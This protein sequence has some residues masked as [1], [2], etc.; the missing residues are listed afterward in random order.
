MKFLFITVCAPAVQHLCQLDKEMQQTDS[1]IK[2]YYAVE[3]FSPEKTA[4]MI[5]DMAEA[6]CI[7][8][9]LMGA[10]PT[11]IQAVEQGLAHAP[12]QILPYGASARSY[13]RLGKFTAEGMQQKSSANAPSME[14]MKRMQK[15]AKT[16][17]KVLPGKMRDMRN[18]I[19]LMQYFQYESLDSLRSFLLLMRKEYGGEKNLKEPPAPIITKALA[20]YNLDDMSYT[21]DPNTYADQQGF[22]QDLPTAALLFNAYAYPTDTSPCVKALADALS[23][24]CNVLALGCSGAFSDYVDQLKDYL[25]ARAWKPVSVILNCRPF[26]LGAGPMGGDT[27]QA[28]DLLQDTDVPYLHPFFLT[29]RTVEDWEESI[30]GCSPSEILISVMLPEMDGI[31]DIVP[32]GA[33]ELGSYEADQDIQIYQ[34]VPI[35]ERIQHLANRV[36][37]YLTLQTKPNAEK[38]LAIL[39]YNYPPGEASLFGGAFL[40]TF[41]SV[42]R[43]LT[44][45]VKE[46]YH[47]KALTSQELRQ[48]FTAGKAVNSGKFDCSWPDMIH[49]STRH[50]RAPQEVTEVWGKA[51]GNIMAEE[52]DFLIPGIE[53]GNVFIGL[54]PARSQGPDQ[55]ASYHDKTI[56]PHHQY[57]AFYQWIREEFVADALIHVGTHGTLEFLKGKEAALSKDCYPDQLIGDLPHLYLYYCGNPSEAIVAKRRSY[58]QIISYQPPVFR[59]SSLYGEYLELS[60]EIDNYHQALSLSPQM[61][62][63]IRKKIASLAAKLNLSDDLE[64]LEEELYRMNTSLIPEGLHIFGQGLTDEEAQTYAL[65]LLR[66]EREGIRPLAEI[67]A[68]FP[69]NAC[70]PAELM[71]SFWESG[72]LPELPELPELPNLPNLPDLPRPEEAAPAALNAREDLNARADFNARED[73]NTQKALNAREDLQKAFAWAKAAA[74]PSQAPKELDGLIHALQGTYTPAR[75]AGDIYRSPEVLPSGYNLYQFDSRLVPSSTAMERGRMICDNTLQAY[76]NETGTWPSSTAVILWGLET[77][78][79]QGE[80]LG[81][82]LA[83]LGIRRVPSGSIWNLQLEIIPLEELGRPRIDVTVNICGFFRDM[84]PTL[85]EDLD[86]MLR[87]L[88]QLD[89]PDDMNFFRAHAKARYKKLLDQ[90]YDPKEAEQLATARIFGPK[91]GEYGTSLTGVI[92]NKSWEDEAELAVSFTDSLRYVYTRRKRG[93]EAKGLYEDNL[94]CVE[95]VSQLR[96]NHDYEITDLDHYYEFFGGLAKS[97]ELAK[98]GVRAKQYITDTTGNQPITESAD[99]AV[100]R[101]IRTRLLNPRWIDGLLAHAYHGGTQIA[102]RFENIM[103]LA[104]TTGDVDEWIYDALDETYVSDPEMRQRMIANNPH[105]YRQILEQLAE[106]HARGYWQATEEQLEEIREIYLDLENSLEESL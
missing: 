45:L 20:L 46:G 66:T 83:Y 47:T 18:Y 35:P 60:T 69:Q 98:G 87:E 55:E 32:V 24:F 62:E 33:M 77:S 14:A 10:A 9:D 25:N 73:L 68:V 49:Y 80:T 2:L 70:D 59:E 67:L 97:V 71:K 6:D 36:R 78:Q 51:P 61:A 16:I 105:A 64:R 11:V 56:P 94:K 34:L 28:T 58:A 29:R 17:G 57:V 106:Y 54:Q 72:V 21:E 82:I 1:S 91:E 96:S 63:D 50:Y 75:L 22:C 103:G 86:D 74:M 84:Y 88:Y 8:V 101:G 37:R 39:C 93:Q 38:K 23:P 43:I 79:T 76:R 85:I 52:D 31:T 15:M 100:A 102:K 89:E 53:I 99:K 44:R 42:S 19:L 40:D 7:L 3:E 95:I 92:E 104:A 27:Q 81:Q 5:K 48:I 41:A 90:G 13:L 65:G 26:R 4:R 12:G 30:A